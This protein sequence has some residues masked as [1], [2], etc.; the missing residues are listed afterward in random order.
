MK[1]I[2]SMA[3]ISLAS[4]VFPALFQSF[5]SDARTASEY[6]SYFYFDF[7]MSLKNGCDYIPEKHLISGRQKYKGIR[8]FRHIQKIIKMKAAAFTNYREVEVK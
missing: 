1:W 7:Y 8:Y 5:L 2:A 4:K 3:N 6:E